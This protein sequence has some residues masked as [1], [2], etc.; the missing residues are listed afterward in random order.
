VLAFQARGGSRR[1]DASWPKSCAAA[2]DPAHRRSETRQTTGAEQVNYAR[3]PSNQPAEAAAVALPR[4]AARVDLPSQP[5]PASALGQ[6]RRHLPAGV[7]QGPAAFVA[8]AA[9]VLLFL[10]LA[11]DGRLH[12]DEAAYL[13]TG[14]FLDREA[15]LKGEFIGGLYVSRLLHIAVIAAIVDLVGPG[16]SALAILIGLYFAALLLVAGLAY[17]ILRKV[18]SDAR[19]LGVAVI[20]GMFT[21]I[22]LYLAFK[23]IAEIPGLTMASIATWALLSALTGRRLVWL[24]V[25][26]LALAAT[27]LFK[28]E[29]MLLYVSL[30]ATLLL[31]GPDRYPRRRLIGYVLV[32]GLGALAVFAAALGLLGIDLA[33]YLKMAPVLV[34]R[35]EPLVAKLLHIAL[36]GGIFFLAVP[37]AFLS[38]RRRD[39]WFCLTWFLLATLPIPLLSAHVESRFLAPNLMALIGLIYLAADGLAPRV[40]AWWRTARAATA[41][42]AGLLFL[43]I[44]GSDLIAL[45]VMTHELRIDQLRRLIARLD[46]E[47]AN[48]NYAILTPYAYT[49]FHYLRFVYPDRSIYTVQTVFKR[50]PNNLSYYPGRV[51]TNLAELRSIDAELVYLGFHENFAVANLRRIVEVIPLPILAKQFDKRT[52]QDHLTLSWMWGNRDLLFEEPLR[53]GHYLAYPVRVR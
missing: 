32:S 16:P 15:I 21:P 30:A 46:Q 19:G 27:A 37:L 7:A 48:R 29:T 4:A 42:A 12:W 47:Y 35:Q 34:H 39:V 3:D 41:G 13:Y 40:V 2:S 51:I 5:R 25:V 24:P 38:R 28:P 14:G 22:Y 17:L 9:L 33:L 20:C 18:L 31:F 49:N 10:F 45:S 1:G 44:V 36:E 26:S 43:A 8:A 52:F 23:T 6:D 50:P 11:F 53:E